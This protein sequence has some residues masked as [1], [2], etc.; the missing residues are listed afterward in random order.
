MK[1]YDNI[2]EAIFVER[3]NR[4]VVYV[5]IGEKIIKAHLPNPGRMWELLFPGV[6]MYVTPTSGQDRKTAYKVI[7]IERDGVP[8]MLDTQYSNMVAER[9]IEAKKIP[10]WE[11][12]TVVRREYTVGNSR[13]DL[14]LHDGQG[15]RFLVEVKPCTLFSRS[16]AMFPDAVTER[17]RK[18]LLELHRLRDEGWR[19]G[20]LFMIQWGRAQ[21]FLPDYHT[22]LA[23]SRAF[24]AVCRDLDWKALVLQW[25]ATFSMPEVV[26]LCSFNEDV[27][28]L[29]GQ[30]KGDYIIVLHT[31]RDIHVSIGSKGNL[32]FPA[33][34]YLY[35]GSA[36]AN[37]TKRI[38]RHKRKRKQKH[39]HI[40]YFREHC[41]FVAALPI[42]TSADLEC[43][44]ADSIK[45]ISEW[46]IPGFGCSDCHCQSH[47][48]AMAKN[49][50][51]SPA[52]MDIVEN[53]R[54]NRLDDVLL[55]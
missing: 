13:F 24:L 33:G 39:W 3:I 52:F 48:F 26:R 6:L 5:C 54:M 51:H 55:P 4:F 20:V 45:E 25:D 37:L 43:P 8:I 11:Q 49:P 31:S 30:D 46:T 23:F 2:E 34:Y 29:E 7:G 38:E 12:Y 42:R 27:L 19:T 16:G 1:L 15:N 28:R 53:Y 36:K 47:L 10:G 40:D 50:I 44:I 21:W 9:L 35:V 18:H 41:E 14:L 22:D 17:G 32:F